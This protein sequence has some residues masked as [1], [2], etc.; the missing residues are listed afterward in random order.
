MLGAYRQVLRVPGSAAFA[1]AG[2]IAR[3]PIS[4]QTLGTVLLVADSTGS[5]ALAGSVSATLAVAQALLAPVLG[6][7][8]DRYGQARVLVPALAVHTAGAAAL[9][10][11]ALADLPVW[12]LFPAAAVW[13]GSF[14]QA[15]ALV[16]SRWAHALGGSPLLPT[17]FSLESVL[18]EVVFVVGP[19]LVT[20][21]A[22]QVA[23]T[24]GVAA[25]WAFAAVGSLALAALRRTEPP[26]HPR[27][28]RRPSALRLSGLRVMIVLGLALGG[29]FGS[30]EVATVAFTDERGT[31]GSAGIVL[32]LL[33]M[34]SL[35]S[36]L[37]YGTVSWRTPPARRFVLGVTV[38]ALVTVP[39][40]A[41]G[42]VPAL[43]VVV[44]LAG[45]AISPALIAGFALLEQLVPASSRTEGLTWF[46]TGL[47]LGVAVA[48]SV[49]GQVVDASGARTAFAVTV[50]AG[51]LSALI[52]LAGA[53]TFSRAG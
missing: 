28:G 16:R 15:G 40:L 34:G 3:F 42:N 53:R 48:A 6:R 46:S 19:V 50:A 27:T 13:G 33:A 12:T 52:A 10:A 21:L 36:G 20:T 49:S 30:I 45:F 25:A 26:A 9:I 24:V 47:G 5:Y 4:M 11:C 14:A 35:L 29:I 31:P 17:A 7:L 22:T 2:L 43:A 41:A 23:P 39:L 32:A 1:A 37:G 18:D 8:V 38:L 51:V 44:F